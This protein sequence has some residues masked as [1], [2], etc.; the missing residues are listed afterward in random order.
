[1]VVSRERVRSGWGEARRRR[2]P[3]GG[4][5]AGPARSPSGADICLPI[6]PAW[7]GPVDPM[8]Q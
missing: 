7:T 3:L 5:A 2:I 8:N 6:A 1:M 4:R